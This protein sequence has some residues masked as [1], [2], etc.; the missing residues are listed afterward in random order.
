MTNQRLNLTNQQIGKPG[1]LFVQ[2]WLLPLTEFKSGGIKAGDDMRLDWNVHCE[3][4]RRE[5]EFAELAIDVSA[6]LLFRKLN[7]ESSHA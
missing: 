6:L 2:Y 1:E 5:Y 4:K 7:N 3:G